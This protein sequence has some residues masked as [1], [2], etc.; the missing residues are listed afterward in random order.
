MKSSTKITVAA[1]LSVLML[2][3]TPSRAADE[4]VCEVSV[5]ALTLPAGSD[6]LLHW[7]APTAGTSAL[8]LSTRYFSEPVKLEGNIIQFFSEA[9]TADAPPPLPDPLLSMKVRAD[10]GLVYIVLWSA[11]DEN[12]RPKWQGRQ[13][14]ARDW[15]KS[16]VKVLNGCTEN[17]GIIAGKKKIAL[18]RGKSVDFDSRDW[19]D[20]FPVKIYR[21][22]VRTKPV[23]SSTWRVGKG[24]RELSFLF[25]RGGSISIR[26]LMVLATP[27]VK[28]DT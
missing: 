16:S 28:D 22:S 17:L 27:P 20:S 9:V 13:F 21:E 12:G 25:D 4:Q 11:P 15:S 3:A 19:E 18:P 14:L 8:Q 6:G 10:L 26:S 24:R 5:A 1:Y 2:V 23:F 7:R